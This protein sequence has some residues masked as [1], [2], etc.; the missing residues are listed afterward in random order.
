MAFGFI[1]SAKEL[2]RVTPSA[3]KKVNALE[4][5]LVFNN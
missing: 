2:R 1:E 4:R 5:V 3:K